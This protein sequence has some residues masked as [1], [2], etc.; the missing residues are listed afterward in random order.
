MH[1]IHL[2]V[3]SFVFGMALYL[4]D[5]IRMAWRTIIGSTAR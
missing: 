5:Q 4:N 3:S 2:I 1:W